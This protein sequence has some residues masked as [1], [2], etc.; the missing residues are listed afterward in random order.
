MQG[1]GPGFLR[2]GPLGAHRDR[3]CS[4]PRRARIAGALQRRGCVCVQSF[5]SLVEVKFT[6][7]IVSKGHNSVAFSAFTM[8]CKQHPY[9]FPEHS[10]PRKWEP[11]QPPSVPARQPRETAV[12]FCRSMAGKGLTGRSLVSFWTRARGPRPPD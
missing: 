6:I 9:P 1:R 12:C 2:P 5:F 4:A 3:V 10:H 7:E 11:H 8:P